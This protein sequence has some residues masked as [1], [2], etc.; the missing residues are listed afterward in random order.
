MSPIRNGRGV[1]ER[2][3]NMNTKGKIDFTKTDNIQFIEEV[4][5]EI[6]KEDKN[7]QW[8]AREIKQH[9]LLLWWEYLEDE[10]QEGFRIEYDEAE[11]VFSVYDE[12]D[13]DITAELEERK[14]VEAHDHN[15]AFFGCKAYMYMDDIPTQKIVKVSRY[16]TRDTED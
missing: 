12:L 14:V 7:W 16:S 15:E 5:R 4:A 8:E 2:K 11:E 6:S 9:S 3:Y 10:K 1:S 13:N